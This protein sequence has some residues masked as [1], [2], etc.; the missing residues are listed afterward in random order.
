MQ[1]VGSAIG[2]LFSTASGAIGVAGGL[3]QIDEAKKVRRSADYVQKEKLRPEYQRKLRATEMAALQGL[4][5]K[6]AYYDAFEQ[7]SA[8]AIEN[9]KR[10]SPNAASTLAAISAALSDERQRKQQLAAMEAKG[11]TEGQLRTANVLGEIG[12][13]ERKLEL[14]RT[15]KRENVLAAADQLEKA[16]TANVYRSL[17]GAMSSMGMGSGALFNSALKSNQ[18]SDA[19]E[20]ITEDVADPQITTPSGGGGTNISTGAVPS[21]GGGGSMSS[22]NLAALNIG[23][24]T[25]DNAIFNNSQDNQFPADSYPSNYT[26]MT[27]DELK[28]LVDWYKQNNQ[29]IP[30]DL[31]KY[32]KNLF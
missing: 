13:E 15:R 3:K 20:G 32:T 10:A 9:I 25:T 30:K 24:P 12:A 17:S 26:Q 7:Q 2:S 16:G 23:A 31:Q 6:D 11:R 19:A 14:E 5:G 18:N 1:G 29:P 28:S 8:N 27:F 22:N 21:G 4:P